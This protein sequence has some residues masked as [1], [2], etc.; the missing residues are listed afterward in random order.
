MS[1]TLPED[2]ELDIK[3]LLCPLPLVRLSQRI[4]AL[5]I[6]DTLRAVSDDPACMAEIPAWAK[7]AGQDLLYA[8]RDGEDY[9]FVIRRVK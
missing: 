2:V 8:E 1:P 5:N 9:V 3:G 6:G 7:S 4:A